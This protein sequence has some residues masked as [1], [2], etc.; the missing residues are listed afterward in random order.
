V[1]GEKQY[2]CTNHLG[3][4]LATVSDW[5]SGE[6][7]MSFGA[8]QYYLPDVLSYSDYY[9]FGMQMPG[10][11]A[12]TGDYR[13]GFQGQETDNEVTGSESHVSYKYRMHD[14]RLGRFL[15]LDPLSPKYPHYSP[16]SFSGNKVIAFI[17]LEGAEE[18][19]TN[20]YLRKYQSE[21]L[22]GSEWAKRSRFA[23]YNNDPVGG[24]GVNSFP[25]AN[26]YNTV[27]GNHELYTSISARSYYYAWVD[28]ATN[29][30]QGAIKSKWFAAARTVTQMN[31]VGAAE[32]INL[33]FLSDD[34]EK[35]LAGGNKFLFEYNMAN[36]KQLITGQEIEGL[37]GLKGK[38]LD[39]ALV[40]FEQSKVQVFMEQYFIDNPDADQNAIINQVNSS[41]SLMFG[42]GD[43]LSAIEQHFTNSET[44]EIT[45]DFSNYDDRVKLGQAVIDILYE[46]DENE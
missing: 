19:S 17:E 10:R 15:S 18:L 44:G 6:D 9:P 34:T 30:T 22:L 40:E 36:A 12:S 31:A 26:V 16:Y 32:G 27:H 33:W 29:N 1:I 25:K 43:V 28:Y 35:F 8:A 39:Y 2:E 37:E 11:N 3:N 7:P 46:R 41:F 20:T 13:Y 42:P 5:K 21:S 14:A 23:D 4:V 38:E 24:Y 45:F